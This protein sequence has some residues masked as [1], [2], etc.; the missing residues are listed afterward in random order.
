VPNNVELR[1]V[2]PIL[3]PLPDGLLNIIDGL[4][5]RSSAALRADPRKTGNHGS[6]FQPRA[7]KDSKRRSYIGPRLKSSPIHQYFAGRSSQKVPCVN[8]SA[9]RTREP[10][11]RVS[12][13]EVNAS[14]TGN[15]APSSRLLHIIWHSTLVE[16]EQIGFGVSVAGWRA[17]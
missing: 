7:A 2:K 1:V 3:C 6:P 15:N 12:N 14:E 16:N 4:R 11:C 8:S 5:A 9:P 10:K 13:V 17:G